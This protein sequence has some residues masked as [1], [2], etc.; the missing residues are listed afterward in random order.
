MSLSLKSSLLVCFYLSSRLLHTVILVFLQ[1]DLE[2]MMVMIIETPSHAGSYTR[3]FLN[4]R[5]Y[6]GRHI[7]GGGPKEN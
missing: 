2:C 3:P 4:S 6:D 5:H 1:G 7:G